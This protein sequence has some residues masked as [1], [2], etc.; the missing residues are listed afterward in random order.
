MARAHPGPERES[1]AD[2]ADL[3]AETTRA[4]QGEYFP[5]GLLLEQLNAKYEWWELR[6]CKRKGELVYEITVRVDGAKGSKPTFPTWSNKSMVIAI[7]RAIQ[8]E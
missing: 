8:G 4:L 7:R 5:S 1:Y 6:R 2:V 3:K